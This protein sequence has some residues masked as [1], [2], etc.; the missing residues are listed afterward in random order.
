MFT[1]RS[2]LKS[3]SFISFSGIISLFPFKVR[4]EQPLAIFTQENWTEHFDQ[5][6]TAK[7]FRIFFKDGTS[8]RYSPKKVYGQNKNS[9]LGTI[10]QSTSSD[11]KPLTALSGWILRNPQLL[12]YTDLEKVNKVVPV[13]VFIMK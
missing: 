9:I 13:K 10:F 4:E 6:L 1:R 7:E 8:V 12:Y 5:I 11:S 2:L 3:L